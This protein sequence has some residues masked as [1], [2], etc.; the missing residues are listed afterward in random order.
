M[1]VQQVTTQLQYLAL[2][3]TGLASKPSE[4]E[5]PQQANQPTVTGFDRIELSAWAI[6]ISREALSLVGPSE[7][8]EEA[9]D[10]S[11]SPR[12]LI[13]DLRSSIDNLREEGKISGRRA[14]HLDRLLDLAA[15]NMDNGR[16]RRANRL[17]LHFSRHIERLTDR[18]RLDQE[19]GTAMIDTAQDFVKQL[20]TER[21]NRR[22]LHFSRHFE[23][24]ADRGRLDQKSGTAMIDSAQDFVKQLRTERHNRPMAREAV[25]PEASQSQD[26]AISV[27]AGVM[28][29]YAEFQTVATQ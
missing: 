21:H 20:R 9:S 5:E 23:R 19:S 25:P 28:L 17:M 1:F 4:A 16:F 14:R 10:S 29:L 13:S 6:T 24:L 12:E 27:R 2:Q 26:R 8:G 18:G 7:V 15:K 11:K 3:F 22:M